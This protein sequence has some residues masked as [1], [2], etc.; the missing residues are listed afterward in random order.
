MRSRNIEKY[1]SSLI[2]FIALKNKGILNED[3]FIKAE[4][5]LAKKYCINKDSLYRTNDLINN[6]FRVI[7]VLPKKEKQNGTEKKDNKDRSVTKVTKEN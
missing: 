5:F 2:H 4:N 6:R 3:D 7:Y 1:F